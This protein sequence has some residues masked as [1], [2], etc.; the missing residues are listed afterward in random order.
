MADNR[1]S[2]FEV[3]GLSLVFNRKT[4]TLVRLSCGPRTWLQSEPAG[5]AIWQLH[6]VD[7][8]GQRLDLE[9]AAAK[10]ATAKIVGRTLRLQWRGVHHAAA[11]AGPFDVQVEIAP[12][13]AAGLTSWRMNVKN[14]SRTWT[15]WHF[16]FPRLGGL[17]AG[18]DAATDR[19]FWPEMWGMQT[20]GWDAMTEITG[21]CGGYGK[22]SMQFMGFSRGKHT[23]YV[24]SHDPMHWS[25]T[26][27]FQPAKPGPGPRKANIN[28]L[29]HPE[30][31]TQAGNSYEQPYE[32]VVGDIAGDWFDASKLYAAWA[33]P[34]SWVSEPPANTFAGPREDR[35]VVVWEQ[36]SVN[37]YP[38]DRI[39]KVNGKPPAKWVADLKA[40]K[41]RLGVPMAVHMYHWHQ[42]Q[43]DTN[44]PD[45]FPVKRGLKE[46]VA[47]L[48]KADIPVVPYINGRLWDLSA[49]SYDKQAKRASLKCC[50]Q[51]VDPPQLIS[52]PEHYGNGQLLTTMCLATGFWQDKVVELCRRI[53]K[54]LGCGGVYLDQL[55]CS[56]GKTCVDRSHGHPL[57]G[58]DYWL[59]GYRQL[60]AAIRREIGPRPLL[61]TENN[62]EAC[63]ADFDSLLD[64]SWNKENNV[65]IFPA[66]YW[67][68]GAIHGGDVF[69]AAYDNQGEAFVERMGMRFVWGGQFGWGHFEPLLKKANRPLMDYFTALCRLRKK[70]ATFFCRGEFLRPPAVKAGG[71][72]SVNP[73]KGPVLSGMWS[74]GDSARAAVFLVNVTRKAQRAEVQV[75]DDAWRRGR[76]AKFTVKLPPLAAVAVDVTK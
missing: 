4:L 74:D 47:T 26:M 16:L 17:T 8:V 75:T 27:T 6:V 32:Y 58:G 33:R 21:A 20:S 65:P 71:E 63:V 35:H 48:A 13:G 31:M 15:L 46:L 22:H 11:G 73:L 2:S 29:S 36:A 7:K 51:R 41:R 42:T 18:K 53:V 10:S 60:M 52:W 25:K 66:V 9:G 61:I 3:N 54:E 38:E 67:G 72:A 39:T 43:F 12:A 1:T 44:Y 62:W 30:G 34:Q 14:H 28:F 24:G 37:A 70:Y 76:G 59:K 40:L 69:G 45:Y 55:G 23:L 5:E 49:P 19:V 56:G 68:R 64:T 57:G 50:A